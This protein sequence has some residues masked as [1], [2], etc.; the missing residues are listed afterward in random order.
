[1]ACYDQYQLR[2]NHIVERSFEIIPKVV[3]RCFGARQLSGWPPF[4]RHKPR[5]SF[6]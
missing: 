2:E 3:V 4:W 5:F 6:R 1:M